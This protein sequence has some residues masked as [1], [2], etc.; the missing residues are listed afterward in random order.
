MTERP[1]RRRL[2]RAFDE[3]PYRLDIVEGETATMRRVWKVVR[4][5]AKG[6]P[7]MRVLNACHTVAEAVR[8]LAFYT[9]RQAGASQI[10][11]HEPAEV[12]PCA[13]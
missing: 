3:R 13:T 7:E 10:P 2:A 9:E 1:K 6:R 4:V 5:Y 11:D 12:K 8:L